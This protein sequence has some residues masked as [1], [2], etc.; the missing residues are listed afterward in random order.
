M[1][2]SYIIVQTTFLINAISVNLFQCLRN[3]MQYISPDLYSMSLSQA[4]VTLE[5]KVVA[6]AAAEVTGV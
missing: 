3:A 2:S 5:A 6:V 1:N 4:A